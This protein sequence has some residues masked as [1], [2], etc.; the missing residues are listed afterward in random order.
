MFDFGLR[1]SAFIEFPSR[2]RGKEISSKGRKE[3]ATNDFPPPDSSV[4]PTFARF[5]QELSPRSVGR[6]SPSPL[7]LRRICGASGDD[8]LNYVLHP[9][10]ASPQN[11]PLR[12]LVLS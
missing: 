7:L 2:A 4:T 5:N 6:P 10:S 1:G 9:H 8:P 11:Q 12:S 3:R